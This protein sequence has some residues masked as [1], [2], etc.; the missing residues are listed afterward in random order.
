[1]PHLEFTEMVGVSLPYGRR[2]GQ[3][4]TCATRLLQGRVT[5]DAEDGLSAEQ[6]RAGFIL[7]CVSKIHGSICIDA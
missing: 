5:M 7:P 6:K 3:C 2:Q 4:R 1:M